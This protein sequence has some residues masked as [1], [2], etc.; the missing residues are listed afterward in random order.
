[1][2]F[3]PSD[4]ELLWHLLAK[5]GKVGVKPHPFIDEFIPTVDSNEGLCYTHPQKLPGKA[6]TSAYGG[7][8]VN[9]LCG[10]GGYFTSQYFTFLLQVYL[11][12]LLVCLHY[13]HFKFFWYTLTR[14]HV[15]D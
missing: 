14:V 10:K 9:V 3:D 15:V 4:Q 12:P 5:I 7:Y 11:V 13:H 1:M 2:K 6:N 8:L